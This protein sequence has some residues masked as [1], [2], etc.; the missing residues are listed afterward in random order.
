MFVEMQQEQGEIQHQI[1]HL[2]HSTGCSAPLGN[3]P[4]L[5]LV[6]P[7]GLEGLPTYRVGLGGEFS[8]TLGIAEATITPH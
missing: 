2:H 1:S 4:G 6:C 5:I 7:V 8:L 3:C